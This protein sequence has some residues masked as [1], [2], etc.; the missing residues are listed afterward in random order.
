M[1]PI[2]IALSCQPVTLVG[3]MS[4]TLFLLM[5]WL[6]LLSMAV[7]V[8]GLTLIVLAAGPAKSLPND[9]SV[10]NVI[11][12]IEGRYR[13]AL[14]VAV[15]GL[16]L[17]GVYQWVAFGQTYQAGG[18]LLLGILSFKVLLATG[19]F[20]MLWAF[21]VDSMVDDKAKAWRWVNLL[22][23]VIV[24]MLAGVVRYLHLADLPG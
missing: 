7:I 1:T 9:P 17:S 13:W 8:G 10:T 15:I 18:A 3:M 14:L 22:L 20:A 21:Q 19:V 23:A 12:R 4:A 24:L 5:R 11:R 6:H 2:A 16:I